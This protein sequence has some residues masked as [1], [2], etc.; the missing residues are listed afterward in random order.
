MQLLNYCTE[1]V[2]VD[3]NQELIA[4]GTANLFGSFFLSLPLAGKFLLTQKTFLN[5]QSVMLTFTCFT[6]LQRK[7]ERFNLKTYLTDM[8]TKHRN[9][10]TKYL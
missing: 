8:H 9:R 6:K 5:H 3:A 2:Q 7:P 10:Q 1:F 4:Q